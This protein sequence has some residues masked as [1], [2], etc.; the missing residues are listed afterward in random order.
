MSRPGR[1]LGGAFLVCATLVTACSEYPSAPVPTR[2]PSLEVSDGAHG[3]SDGFYFLPPLASSPHAAG[4]FDGTLSP[5]VRICVWDGAACATTLALF[6]MDEGAGAETVRVSEADEAYLVNWRTRGILADYPLG[7]GETYRIGVWVDGV[8]LGFADVVVLGRGEKARDVDRD[9]F[10]VIREGQTL[11]I[12]FRIEEG[13]V[14]AQAPVET[15]SMGVSA[16]LT[17]TC[18]V[19][20]D[21]EAYCW[22][23]N[24]HGELGTGVAGG[25]FNTPQLVSG[26]LTWRA[27]QASKLYSCGLA[28]DE[29]VYCW[30]GNSSGELGIGAADGSSHATP[31]PVAGDLQFATLAALGNNNSSST[32]GVT[33]DGDMYCWGLNDRGQLGTGLVGGIEPSPRLV[34]GGHTFAGPA[35][36]GRSVTCGLTTAGEVLCW[37]LNDYG[38]LGR[39]YTSAFYSPEPSPGLVQSDLAFED[40]AVGATHACAI[41]DSGNAWCWGRNDDAELGIG[42]VGGVFSTPQ[43][44]TGGHVFERLNGGWGF[45]CGIDSVGTGLCWGVNS[46]GQLGRG[47]ASGADQPAPGPI[48]GGYTFVDVAAGK[49]HACGVTVTGETYCWGSGSA[50]QLGAG[51]M[52]SS[53][54]PVL[55]I[56][57]DPGS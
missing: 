46:N 18:A 1:R 27:V 12:K 40:V 15:I 42:S 29:R 26:G 21:G 32:C 23:A 50:G 19:A 5:E 30:G 44:V 38:Q 36:L 47:F 24:Q 17:H 10:V 56:D 51:A 49:Q 43:S 48:T 35:A 20:A 39:G 7:P 14:L 16:G 9:E 28:T 25:S 52:M 33:T 55:A 13:M 6:T 37:G 8:E 41:D 53:S 54:T 34:T 57:L 3:G 22:G 2:A 11:A 45:T 4:T 31:L